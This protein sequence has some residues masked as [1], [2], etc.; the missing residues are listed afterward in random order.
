MKKNYYYLIAG[1]PELSLDDSKLGIT[2]RE[3]RELYY[4]EL[5]DDDRALLDLIYLSYDNANLLLLLK[6]KEA[7]IVEGGLYTS[8]ELL[9]VIEAARAEETPDRRYPRYMYDF[10]AQMESEDSAAEGIFPE[11]R[12]AQLY[13]AHAMSQGNVFVERWFA[14]NLDLNNFLTAITARR[15]N[16]DVKPLIVG[17]NEVA[18]ALRTSNSR[19]FGLTGVMDGF[20]EV[21]RI[22]EID[23]LVERER[24]LDI[25]KWEWMEEN[26]FFDYFTVE[27]LF[28]FLVKIQII[29][30]WITLDAEAGGEMLRGMIRQL[31]DEVKVPQEFTINNKK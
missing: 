15:Y 4:P 20:E 16:L 26:S 6:D 5:A 1:L 19:D 13:Y 31:K 27:K 11:D 23:N 2:V 7:A 10:V 25:L 14:F 12:L 8:E 29:E 21:M 22:S 30:R 24:K 28:A 9:G 18:K 3:F 17:D